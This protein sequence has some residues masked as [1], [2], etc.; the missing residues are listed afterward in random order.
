M[1]AI[2]HSLTMMTWG[3]VRVTSTLR[4]IVYCAAV[5]WVEKSEMILYVGVPAAHQ[6][7]D[8][9]LTIRMISCCYD[10]TEIPEVASTLRLDA[11]CHRHFSRVQHGVY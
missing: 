4:R 1:S 5:R 9:N 8:G 10:R 6:E 2:M 7:K 3:R 11:H